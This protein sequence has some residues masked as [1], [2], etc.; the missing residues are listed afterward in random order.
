MGRHV[1]EGFDDVR[2]EAMPNSWKGALAQYVGRLHRLH[3]LKRE[4]QV[5]GHVVG[6]VASLKRMSEKRIRGSRSF[7]Y[8]VEQGTDRQ[9]S[10]W[11]ER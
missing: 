11:P 2:L 9:L 3:A 1:G 6:V 8:T 7:G 5:H 10:L 4:V